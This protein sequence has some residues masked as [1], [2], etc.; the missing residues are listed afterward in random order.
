MALKV[1]DGE[2]TYL[3]MWCPYNLLSGGNSNK[4][5]HP[6]LNVVVWMWLT[7]RAIDLPIQSLLFCTFTSASQRYKCIAVLINLQWKCKS[8]RSQRYLSLDIFKL[9]VSLSGCATLETPKTTKK[10]AREVTQLAI[11]M[12]SINLESQIEW[13]KVHFFSPTLPPLSHVTLNFLVLEILLSLMEMILL[14]LSG[15]P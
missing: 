8:R 3:C 1:A 15:V 6:Q 11:L 12:Q 10:E 9:E 4:H 2:Y 14:W 7:Q 5:L 13:M